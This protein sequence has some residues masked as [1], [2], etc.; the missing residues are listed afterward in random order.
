ML[1]LQSRSRVSERRFVSLILRKK[2]GRK[3][4]GI[5]QSLSLD[6][7]LFKCLFLL[8]TIRFSLT[9]IKSYFEGLEGCL[10]PNQPFIRIFQVSMHQMV[11]SLSS[12]NFLSR[13]FVC[14]FVVF[15]CSLPM[16][17]LLVIYKSLIDLK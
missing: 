8:D 14:L 7:Q 15:L 1:L 3:E 6:W 10:E 9:F 4:D 11:R 17:L 13:V 2:G 12:V 16:V 5:K